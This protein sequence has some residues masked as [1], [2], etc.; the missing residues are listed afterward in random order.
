M[1]LGRTA[2][3]TDG[4]GGGEVNYCWTDNSD[5]GFESLQSQIDNFEEASS[6]NTLCQELTSIEDAQ[7]GEFCATEDSSSCQ[8]STSG[9]EKPLSPVFTSNIIYIFYEE[10]EDTSDSLSFNRDR[11]QSINSDLIYCRF[12]SYKTLNECARNYEGIDKVQYA[13]FIVE[14]DGVVRTLTGSNDSSDSDSNDDTEFEDSS[15]TVSRDVEW[16]SW[17]LKT[18]LDG[19]S[20]ELTE[21]SGDDKAVLDSGDNGYCG[22]AYFQK[23]FSVSD[24]TA[25]KLEIDYN[26]VAEDWAGKAFVNAN[27][28]EIASVDPQG[29][30]TDE[31]GTW[32]VYIASNTNTIEFG[33]RDTS[34]DNCQNGD[35]GLRLEVTGVSRSDTSIANPQ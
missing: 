22:K 6:L 1:V 7:A 10:W 9:N 26:V 23:D 3:A 16:N 28:N 35:H 21:A 20:D 2:P 25:D 18:T 11:A 24:T 15:E 17:N 13:K 19:K 33:I 14:I 5:D 34:E 8:Y 31:A 29:E 27:G 32:T 12:N 4:G 30:G